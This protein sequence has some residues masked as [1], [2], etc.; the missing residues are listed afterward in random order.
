PTAGGAARASPPA[1]GRNSTNSGTT[2]AGISSLGV[3]S[4]L[5]LSTLVKSLVDA[6]RAP[7]EN[8]LNRRQSTA[9][10]QVSALGTLSS[11]AGKLLSAVNALKDFET[12][13]KASSS[14]ADTVGVSVGGE[15][16]PGQYRVQV[17]SLAIA[18]SLASEAFEDVDAALGEGTLTVT[19]GDQSIDIELTAE[20]NTLSD[21]R[22]AINASDVGVN[23]VIVR[24]GES[25]R[26]LLTSSESGLDYQIDTTVSGS[27]DTRLAS[28]QMTETAA[29]QDASFSVNGL[30]LTSSG[31]TIDDV[32]P[33]L[34][35]NLNRT[36]EGED[37]IAINVE[38][39]RAATRAKLE[40]VVTAYNAL[41]GRITELG[42]TNIE[43]ASRGPLVGDST[44]RSLEFQ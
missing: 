13:L 31:N 17:Q 5:D 4:G 36:T 29:A 42:R 26:L 25:H 38:P 44:L 35:L 30:Q 2:M 9:K 3:G 37:S 24:D 40:A 14:D 1:R 11:A 8:R 12:S 18:Q 23:A 19:V 21:V 6:E 43:A 7:T 15:A 34:T 27:V 28:A 33:G 39:D 20:A 22:D 10:T 32:I 41:A 16:D